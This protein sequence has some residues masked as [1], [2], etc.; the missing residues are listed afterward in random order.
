[1]GP[2]F[3]PIEAPIVW[4]LDKVQRPTSSNKADDFKSKSSTGP[5]APDGD[6]MGS[7]A[8]ATANNS[9]SRRRRKKKTS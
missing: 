9:K 2:S 7:D 6:S 4:L 5:D 8:P 1:M 3:S